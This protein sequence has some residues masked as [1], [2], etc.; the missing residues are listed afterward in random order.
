MMIIAREGSSSFC[1]LGDT[2]IGVHSQHDKLIDG[3]EGEELQVHIEIGETPRASP[4][5]APFVKHSHPTQRTTSSC[6]YLAKELD[7]RRY[8]KLVLHR[9]IHEVLH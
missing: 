2:A 4:S 8:M 9:L 6:R 1:C 7:A 3:E 5:V